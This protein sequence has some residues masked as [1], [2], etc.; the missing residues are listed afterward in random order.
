[1]EESDANPLRDRQLSVIVNLLRRAAAES[2]EEPEASAS[3][4]RV[5]SA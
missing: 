5:S 2:A 4:E 1:M 3:R